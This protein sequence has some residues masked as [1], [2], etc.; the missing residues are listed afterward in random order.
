[1]RKISLVC[2]PVLAAACGSDDSPATGSVT[3]TV[4]GEAFI[5]QGIPADVFTD[6]WSMSFDKFLVSVGNPKTMAGEGGLEVGADN[7]L[8]VDLAQ[9]SDGEGY[10]LATFDAPG[11]DYDHYG[12]QITPNAGATG[13]NAD[14]ADVAE[15]K[16]AGY[17]IWIQGTATKGAESFDL[18]WGFALKLTYAHCE[19]NQRMDGNSIVMQTTVH[20][21]HLFYDDAISEE[22]GVA[23]QIVADAD[24]ADGTTPDNAI[25]FEELEATDIRAEERYQVGS[26][27]TPTGEPIENLLQYIQHQTTT[28]GHVNGEG[29]CEDTIVTP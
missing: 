22:P 20:S 24:G 26:I 3:A 19:M 8:I 11:G 17:S 12:Y 16:A 21:D 2:I 29:H 9:P 1:L 6:G 14:A 25:T 5:E 18:D 15:M 28:V 10:D 27:T 23:F 4:Y 7:F 13:L